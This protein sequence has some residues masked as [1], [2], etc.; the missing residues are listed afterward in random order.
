MSR[1]LKRHVF[2]VNSGKQSLFRVYLLHARTECVAAKQ[3]GNPCFALE[4][5]R[6]CRQHCL[7]RLDL[8]DGVLL[9]STLGAS[10]RKLFRLA[11]SALGRLSSGVGERRLQRQHSSILI[12]MDSNDTSCLLTC[13]EE[14]GGWED[15]GVPSQ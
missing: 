11:E 13:S 12:D 6:R 3:L 8:D 7:K 2:P 9:G 14:I 10:C 5:L 15:F 4:V 1:L